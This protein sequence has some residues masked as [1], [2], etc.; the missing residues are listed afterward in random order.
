MW[1][2]AWASKSNMNRHVTEFFGTH[3]TPRVFTLCAN[4]V[5]TLIVI[6]NVP[7]IFVC[8]C[9][10]GCCKWYVYRHI[11]SYYIYYVCSIE[12]IIYPSICVSVLQ[13]TTF[14]VRTLPCQNNWMRHSPNIWLI[15]WNFWIAKFAHHLFLIGSINQ[16]INW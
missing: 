13:T 6:L 3:G 1:A 11:H 9:V 5:D 8:V 15:F 4:A 14:I 2:W 7:K 16:S 12:Y 10:C